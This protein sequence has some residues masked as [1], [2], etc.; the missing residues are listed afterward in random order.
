MRNS[1]LDSYM[2]TSNLLKLSAQWLKNKILE[3]DL[4]GIL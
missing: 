3:F 4:L 1:T 2:C